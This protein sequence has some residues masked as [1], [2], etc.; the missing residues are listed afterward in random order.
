PEPPSHRSLGQPALG[1]HNCPRCRKLVST[2]VDRCPQCGH[3]FPPGRPGS[4][5]VRLPPSS[6]G[7][8]RAEPRIPVDLMAVYSSDTISFEARAPDVSMGGAFITSELLEPVG[9]TC[10]VALL[11]DGFPAF[12]F[13]AR[14]VHMVDLSRTPRPAGIGVRFLQM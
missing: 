1:V 6:Q 7:D 14:V 9:T 4:V 3:Q 10:Q 12:Y 13:T 5:T 11:P 8:R 2:D